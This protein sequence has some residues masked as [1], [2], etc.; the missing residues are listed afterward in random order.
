M[1]WRIKFTLIGPKEVDGA[2]EKYKMTIFTAVLMAG[3]Y[4]YN[5][6]LVCSLHLLN[7]VSQSTHSFVFSDKACD[8]I[9]QPK[10]QKVIS[11]Q[12]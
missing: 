7:T 2:R 3:H 12:C 4:N 9:C 1:V 10:L 8:L 6:Y 5:V 11:G